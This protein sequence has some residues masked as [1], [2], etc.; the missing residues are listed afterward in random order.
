M[1]GL[2]GFPG[3]EHSLSTGRQS[4][5]LCKHGMKLPMPP[6]PF[7]EAK[8]HLH[9]FSIIQQEMVFVL[10]PDHALCDARPAQSKLL[11]VF[12]THPITT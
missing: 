10:F 3:L 2:G 4:E 9:M 1:G 5:L 7:E 8:I 12:K 6:Q 11:K